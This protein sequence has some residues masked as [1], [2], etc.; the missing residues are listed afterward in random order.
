MQN[1]VAFDKSTLQQQQRRSRLQHVP[2]T[3][4][5][6][7]DRE[8]H[9]NILKF[10]AL[11]EKTQDALE[12]KVILNTVEQLKKQMAQLLAQ[13]RATEKSGLAGTFT[14]GGGNRHSIN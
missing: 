10:E 11:L 2:S 6:H 7:L 3:G 14:V 8:L 1:S 13:R 4:G 12:K 5:E 9:A